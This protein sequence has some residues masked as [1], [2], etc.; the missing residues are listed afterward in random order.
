MIEVYFIPCLKH[1]EGKGIVKIVLQNFIKANRPSSTPRTK[2][3]QCTKFGHNFERNTFMYPT[4]RKETLLSHM[5]HTLFVIV[6][7]FGLIFGHIEGMNSEIYR[8]RHMSRLK[9]IRV[10]R[11]L[12]QMLYI[13]SLVTQLS[14]I[15]RSLLTQ[16]TLL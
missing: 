5:S 10:S 13:V 3:G 15:V 14:V 4:C 12:Q 2:Q 1:S 9:I 11:L 6:K 8:Q 7:G 16:L